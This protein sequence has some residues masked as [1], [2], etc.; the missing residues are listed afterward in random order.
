MQDQKQNLKND[1]A[2]VKNYVHQEKQSLVA[3][4][5]TEEILKDFN[6]SNFRYS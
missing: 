6:H 2:N 4:V 1:F 3:G 5:E